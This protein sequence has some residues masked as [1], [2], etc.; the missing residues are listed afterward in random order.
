[1]S[2]LFTLEGRVTR[3]S[4]F[5]TT[6][7]IIVATAILSFVFNMFLATTE[8]TASAIAL[9]GMLVWLLGTMMLGCQIVRRLHDIDR[10]GWQF[11]LFLVPIYNLYLS[12]VLFF[13]SG[14]TGPNQFGN[15]PGRVAA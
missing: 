12:A 8:A 7:G 3:T 15:D 13:K 5:I 1:M 10:S 11:W 9:V 6:I 4:Y 14:T 2:H